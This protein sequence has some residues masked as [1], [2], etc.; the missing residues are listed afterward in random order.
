MKYGEEVT[1]LS[2][3]EG[4]TIEVASRN[5]ATGQQFTRLTS[6]RRSSS[7][8]SPNE[9]SIYLTE[10]III[11]PGG[12]S[13]LPPVL[14]LL[15]PHP[16]LVHSSQYALSVDPILASIRSSLSTPRPLRIAIV[17]SGQSSSEILLNLH[18]RL[19][20]VPTGGLGKHE[21]DLIFRKGSLKPSDDSPFANEIFDPAC[22]YLLQN[23]REVLSLISIALTATDMMF[24]LRSKYERE[25]VLE[26]YKNTNYGVVNPRTIDNVSHNCI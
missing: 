19:S 13:K 3:G 24:N 17:G 25:H 22:T 12:A 14:S 5:N 20:S 2:R 23:I 26:E 11:S 21:L 8:Y 10:N 4:G 1:G 15:T 18:G 7:L 16:R 9:Y 6:M